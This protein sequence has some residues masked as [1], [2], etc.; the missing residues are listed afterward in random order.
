MAV[1]ADSFAGTIGGGIMEHRLISE[2]RKQMQTSAAPSCRAIR[3][4]HDSR[5]PSDHSGMICAGE[6]TVVVSLLTQT[7]L[8]VLE[9]IR[10]SFSSGGEGSL[11]LTELGLSFVAETM[12]PV[13]TRDGE[14]FRYQ[15]AVVSH[16]SFYVV[17]GGHVGLAL[18]RVMATLDFEVTVLDHRPALETLEENCHAH[19]KI[20]LGSYDE[21]PV[22]V[23]EGERSLVAIVSTSFKTDEAALRALV[24]KRFAY[25]GVMGSAAK[26]ARIFETLRAEGAD[27]A[28]LSR[29]RA[30]IG[31]PIGSHT[32]EEIAISIAAEVIQSS[33]VL[34]P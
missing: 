32:P 13:L 27:E 6:Q 31:L 4:V 26:I 12:G 11:V 16:R 2:S 19:E 7:D 14:S 34:R 25:L 28:M 18:S 9:S 10:H 29:V 21:L 24:G 17:G 5:A 1:T 33:N 30:P 22:H 20:I 3:Q 8:P 15:E 23:R